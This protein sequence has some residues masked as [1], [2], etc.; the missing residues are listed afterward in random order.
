MV[1]KLGVFDS[2]IGGEAIA[3][4]LRLTFPDE[5][6]ITV[7]DHA[8]VP[9]GDKTPD[10]VIELTNNAIQPLLEANC[11]IIVIACNTATA[12]AIDA[13]RIR[14][15]KQKFIG[16]EPMVKTAAKLTKSHIIAVCATPATL[17]SARYHRLVQK[18]GANLQTIEPDCRN[19]AQMIENSQINYQIIDQ[20]VNNVCDQ[21][22][23]VIVLGCTHY[24]WIKDHIIKQSAG[25]AQV[26]EPSE[27]IGRRVKQLLNLS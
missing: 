12:L 17:A 10:E 5:E 26:I 25:R 13:L 14:Y 19:W 24:N 21:G 16:I 7:N 2:G 15:P 22:A 23:D 3:N 9:Y 20:I 18:F 1:M 11:D 4:S 8:H 27:S 6:V